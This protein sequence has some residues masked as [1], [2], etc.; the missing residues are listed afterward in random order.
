[1]NLKFLLLLPLKLEQSKKM[2]IHYC[3]KVKEVTVFNFILEADFFVEYVKVYK[4]IATHG[5]PIL[6]LMHWFPQLFINGV[7]VSSLDYSDDIYN[8]VGF[9]FWCLNKLF[10]KTLLF[11]NGA[12]FI[13][14]NSV[15]INS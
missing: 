6:E 8:P 14:K 3:I 7:S 13:T 15:N 4:H 12:N 2:V 5:F 9:S 1:M 11:T 10:I